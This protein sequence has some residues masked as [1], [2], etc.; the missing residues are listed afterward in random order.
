MA[1]TFQQIQ[2]QIEALTREAQNL[3]KK[4]ISDVVARIKEAIAVYGL[5]AQD[6]GLAGTRGRPPKVKSV[7]APAPTAKKTRKVK[8]KYRDNAGNTWTGRGS[9]P[10]WLRDALAGG[11]SIESFLV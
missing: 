6:L 2:K 3:R 11:K 7:A 1:K 5:T 8:V 4:E 9:R 10:R